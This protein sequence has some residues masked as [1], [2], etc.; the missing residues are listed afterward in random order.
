MRTGTANLPL[1][2]GKAPRW[3]FARMSGLAREITR[4]IVEEEDTAGLLRRLSDPFWFQALGCVLGFDWHSSGL[5]TTTCGA[6]KDGLKGLERELGLF[7]AGGKGGTSRKTP[8]EIEAWGMELSGDP[9]D[10]I[11]ASRMAARVD[12]NALQDGYQLYHHVFI[13]DRQGHWA[14]IQQG[15]NTATRYARRYHW[16]SEGVTDFVDE[17]HAAICCDQTGQV[18][19]LVAHESAE[20]RRVSTLLAAE[21]PVK[22]MGELKRLQHLELPDRH[23]LRLGDLNPERLGSIFVQTYEQPPADFA[24]LLARPGVGPKTIRALSLLAELVYGAPVS[25]RDPA[26][27]SFAHG[28]KDGYPYPVD[29]ATY[30]RS[31]ETLKAALDRAK[32]GDREKLEAFRRLAV[33]SQ[34]R[35]PAFHSLRPVK[36]VA[37]PPS[38]PAGPRQL[39]FG[40]G[41]GR[42]S[43]T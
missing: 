24:D 3:L 29:R 36:P 40:P 41:F 18:I 13:F 4:L 42:P 37:T 1:H 2:H 26:R 7:V 25:T 22:L 39:D 33:F 20:A 6:L 23:D 12:N 38:A 19:N 16:L 8:A 31:I 11:Y 35:E 14:V 10:L 9:A 15:M 32:V 27:F 28:G 17:P 5:T 43:S 21:K 30:D 34:G